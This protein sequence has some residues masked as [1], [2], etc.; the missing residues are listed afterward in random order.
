MK[1]QAETTQVKGPGEAKSLGGLK[2]KKNG[3]SKVTG[4]ANIHFELHF[5]CNSIM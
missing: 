1:T 3:E 4:K 2:K 5:F